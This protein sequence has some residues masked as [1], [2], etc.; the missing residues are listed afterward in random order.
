MRTVYTRAEIDAVLPRVDA[1]EAVAQ[2]FVAFSKG[3]V[4]VAPVGELLFPENSG[5]L[6]IKF[7][8]IRGDDVFV[9]KLAT[10][11]FNN[12]TIGLPP[13][14]GCMIVLSQ[15][16]G[17]I[18]A[19][20]LEEGEL[21]NHRTAA[22]GAVAA[23]ALA[24]GNLRAIGIVGT[25]VQARL[26]ADYLR[27]VTDCR[28]LFIWG[29]RPEATE[30]A[31]ADIGRMGFQVFIAK[32]L[33]ELCERSRL[34]V[35]TTPAE[36]PLLTASMVRPG[37]HITAMGSDTAEKNELAAELLELADLVVADSLAQSEFRGEIYQACKAGVLQRKTVVELGTVLSGAA[38]GRTSD[39]QITIAD[40]TGVAV[41]DIAIAKAVL[42]ELRSN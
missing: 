34:I 33:D 17:V 29:R 6:H 39:A 16:T 4:E 30:H 38:V 40:L 36:H 24:P 26:Q 28:D 3:D 23:K 31:A 9:V 25:G 41:Q 35:T 42:R 32:G 27:R 14:N 15:K 37:T 19:V 13:F 7:G 5:E 22:A 10:G 18:D 21:T 20:L 1:T 11:F 2:G 8:A 12:P